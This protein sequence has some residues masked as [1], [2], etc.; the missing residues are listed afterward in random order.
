MRLLLTCLG[1][2]FCCGL[3]KA[4]I[5]ISGRVLD[6]TKQNYVES[7][8]VISTGGM[9]SITDSM[10]RYSI[11]VHIQDSI[12]FIYNNKPTQKFPVKT[13]TN[14]NDFDISLRIPVK[15]KYSVLKEV[16]VY[17]KTFRQDSLENRQTYADVFAYKKPGVS[18]SI[19]PDGGVGADVNELINIF[20]FKRNKRLKAFRARV[21]EQENESYINY[22][23]NK[24]F[25]KRLTGLE[26]P[27]LDSFMIWHRPT[28]EFTA[29]STEIEFNQ[30]ILN[31]Y[32]Q[33][34]K[35]GFAQPGK[36][37]D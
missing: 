36:L 8:Q 7:A 10:G 29:N 11:T 1:I 31:S 25:V 37:N 24:S 35:M 22:R 17:S 4:Q 19:T 3:A 18:T 15:G 27:A 30:Y 2:F 13:I 33:F 21:E 14:Y 5:I 26:S 32:Y 16:V 9:F 6:N 34:K 20:R 12:Y 28:Y 23:F